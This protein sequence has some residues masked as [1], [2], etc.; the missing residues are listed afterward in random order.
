MPDAQHPPRQA[1][2]PASP[3]IP[4]GGPR[5]YAVTVPDSWALIPLEPGGI[6]FYL[7]LMKAGPLPVPASLLVTLIPVP[8]L[9]SRPR[10]T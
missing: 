6:E 7:S 3:G 2:A 10:L 8:S 5:D 9:L 4:P 1:S